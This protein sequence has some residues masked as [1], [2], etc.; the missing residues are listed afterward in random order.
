MIAVRG[1]VERE[2][3]VWVNSGNLGDLYLTNPCK[4]AVHIHLYF[5]LTFKGNL[6]IEHPSLI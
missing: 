3:F 4:Q 5:K 1:V 6:A 2:G